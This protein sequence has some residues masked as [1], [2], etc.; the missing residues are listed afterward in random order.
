MEY[1]Q[2]AE[3]SSLADKI[4]AEL[5]CHAYID[6]R[7]GS[8]VFQYLVLPSFTPPIAWDVFRR[9][10]RR[11]P[12]EFIL[13]R[14]SW[15]SDLDQEKL[16]TP[17]ERVRHPRRLTPTIELH[18]LPAESSVLEQLALRLSQLSLPIGA[19]PGAFGIDGTTFEI[20]IE[21]PPHYSPLA[22]KCRLSWWEKPPTA[23]GALSEW[24]S[25]AEEVFEASWSVRGEASAVPLV[26]TPIDDAAARERARS[27]FHQG[28]YARAAA[29]LADIAT[30]EKLTPAE[31]KMLAL[32][33]KRPD[34]TSAD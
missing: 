31:T 18:L 22:A 2:S 5:R 16:R 1:E 15:R 11:Y 26:I 34:K 8:H 32:A 29:M 12:D 33:G 21:Q 17:V 4:V 10:R 28:D 20:A 27:L 6:E 7:F 23:W 24:L 3:F 30:R 25:R 9:A 19:S 14:T 13:V